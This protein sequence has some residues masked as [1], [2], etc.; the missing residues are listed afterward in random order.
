MLEAWAKDR[1]PELGGGRVG[2]EEHRPPSDG[3]ETWDE[4]DT[5]I[6]EY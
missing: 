2:E 1:E 4:A 3:S 5:K 6:R